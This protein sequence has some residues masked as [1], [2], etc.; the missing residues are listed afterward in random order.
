[1]HHFKIIIDGK[2]AH[3]KS[4]KGTYEY[5]VNYMAGYLQALKDVHNVVVRDSDEVEV[6]YIPEEDLT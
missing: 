1:M 5:A 2:V 4:I 6:I 3:D